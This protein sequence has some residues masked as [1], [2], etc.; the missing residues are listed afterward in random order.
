M[1]RWHEFTPR[2]PKIRPGTLARL[3]RRAERIEARE[4]DYAAEMAIHVELADAYRA[5]AWWGKRTP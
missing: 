1:R 5:I 3:E 4:N 2:A